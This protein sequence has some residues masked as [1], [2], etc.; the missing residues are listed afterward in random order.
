MGRI[1]GSGFRRRYVEDYD[2]RNISQEN[3]DQNMKNV[4][5][6]LTVGTALYNSNLSRDAAAGIEALFTGSEEEKKEVATTAGS[7][8]SLQQEAAKA[9]LDASRI[10]AEKELEGMPVGP[11]QGPPG[12]IPQLQL[13]TSPLEETQRLRD[14][15]EAAIADKEKF[16]KEQIRAMSKRSVVLGSRRVHKEKTL[17]DN[18]VALKEESRK[19]KDYQGQMKTLRGL[20]VVTMEDRTPEGKADY[21]ILENQWNELADKVSPL[22]TLIADLKEEKKTVTADIE[23]LKRLDPIQGPQSSAPLRDE[24]GDK[25]GA[26]VLEDLQAR[27]IQESAKLAGKQEEEIL[28]IVEKVREGR[29]T[30]GKEQNAYIEQLLLKIDPSTGNVAISTEEA[31]D[32]MGDP[33]KQILFAI[34]LDKAKQLTATYA[35]GGDISTA[36][37]ALDEEGDDTSEAAP[38]GIQE[39]VAIE[40]P[41]VTPTDVVEAPVPAPVAA[42]GGGLPDLKVPQGVS[43]TELEKT[44]RQVAATLGEDFNEVR[45]NINA[46]LADERLKASLIGMDEEERARTLITMAK[47]MQPVGATA[48]VDIPTDLTG[49]S[50]AD[51]QILA[52]EIASSNA[53]GH[54]KAR[55]IRNLLE[56]AGDLS[57]VRS[58]FASGG[59]LGYQ[60]EGQARQAIL[61]AYAGSKP[62]VAREQ[63]SAE[64]L[65][66]T[67]E[68]GA[69]PLSAV[70]LAAKQEKLAKD[71]A[72]A[73]VKIRNEYIKGFTLWNQIKKKGGNRK[74]GSGSVPNDLEEFRE[75]LLTDSGQALKFFQAQETKARDR[76]TRLRTSSIPWAS[77]PKTPEEIVELYGADMPRF[78]AA[79]REGKEQAVIAS[80]F[81]KDAAILKAKYEQRI[82][83]TNR[84]KGLVADQRKVLKRLSVD[85][86]AKK[87]LDPKRRAILLKQL[88]AIN[89]KILKLQK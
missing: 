2:K 84:Q 44:Y 28:A 60:H 68:Y 7:A 64:L 77:L 36:Q 61:S 47:Y 46:L 34:A 12:A 88:E 30:L 3:F 5:T 21:K 40:P 74:G 39:D 73:A 66:W 71:K 10:D 65:R 54:A 31:N 81:E 67:K 8:I 89:T 52:M 58:R 80:A 17:E 85:L 75:E 45:P 50:I 11:P 69:T 19:L 37:A 13:D 32:L 72:T 70:E 63:T 29:L 33:N 14:Q 55:A 57:D 25:E 20:M 22:E 4:G 23:N 87:R 78:R 26:K 86:G 42:T 83:D 38:E 1:R 62:K 24:A 59:S 56:Q 48:L 82:K 16:R 53:P 35:T 51:A 41:G 15:A 27:V 49:K 76:I 43:N 79:I 18:A 9:R 6:A